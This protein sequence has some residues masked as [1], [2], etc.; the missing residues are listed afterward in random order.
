MAEGEVWEERG[1]GSVYKEKIV[2]MC[3]FTYLCV[4]LSAVYRI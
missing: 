3:V 2:C 4:Y 1:K